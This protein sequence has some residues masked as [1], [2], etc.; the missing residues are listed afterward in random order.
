MS[1]GQF[2]I[3][4]GMLYA[5]VRR[6]HCGLGRRRRVHRRGRSDSTLIRSSCDQAPPFRGTDRYSPRRYTP[7]PHWR[8]SY[9]L[10][11]ARR[12]SLF[13]R[14][15]VHCSNGSPSSRSSQVIDSVHHVLSGQAAELMAGPAAHC[16]GWHTP[17]DDPREGGAALLLARWL[18][19]PA[20]KRRAL[21]GIALLISGAPCQGRFARCPCLPPIQRYSWTYVCA[22]LNDVPP[23]VQ[24]RTRLERVPAT[25]GCT[26]WKIAGESRG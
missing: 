9:D 15:P 25:D 12:C 19:G 14:H 13:C 26:S 8:Y 17:A 20:E 4:Q 21:V 10:G 23:C 11:C 18:T 3:T 6:V 2:L 22:I 16:L 7:H 5:V 24:W 1:S